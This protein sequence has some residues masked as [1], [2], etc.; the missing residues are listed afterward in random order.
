MEA[1]SLE[2]VEQ[3]RLLEAGLDSPRKFHFRTCP[4]LKL[5]KF[6]N[7]DSKNEDVHALLEPHAKEELV[8]T[9]NKKY[10]TLNPEDVRNIK[11]DKK[12]L[13]KSSSSPNVFVTSDNEKSSLI[14]PSELLDEEQY[15]IS[16]C[17][18]D[19]ISD[20][21]NKS[22]LNRSKFK[23]SYD[24]F[25]KPNGVKSRL[26]STNSDKAEVDKNLVDGH[27]NLSENSAT[28]SE[29][30]LTS[31]DAKPGDKSSGYGDGSNTTSDSES[32]QD[33]PGSLKPSPYNGPKYPS[34][35]SKRDMGYVSDVSTRSSPLDHIKHKS[36]HPMRHKLGQK[37]YF[38][39]D[40]YDRPR[41]P[42]SYKQAI[43]DIERMSEINEITDSEDM[44]DQLIEMEK[45]LGVQ[46]DDSLESDINSQGLSSLPPS[47]RDSFRNN[48]PGNYNNTESGYMSDIGFNR[49]RYSDREKSER[50]AKLLNEFKSSRN[51]RNSPVS[52]DTEVPMVSPTVRCKSVMDNIAE[53]P[54]IPPVLRRSNSAGSSSV[55]NEWLV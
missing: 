25:C 41:A 12:G 11:Q 51:A 30:P 15:D 5:G 27:D 8:C 46:L 44:Y 49:D 31:R 29:C 6:T 39:D 14:D 2:A 38:S 54:R 10:L 37:N 9:C 40:E 55:Y 33:K 18:K 17:E 34:E 26:S 45:Q 21:K 13:F 28:E 19:E 7:Y 53:E 42:P 52:S 22:T 1:K 32:I 48:I 24:Q 47:M 50:C 4:A 35:Y 23:D 16:D 3:K 20:L 43:D 36:Q